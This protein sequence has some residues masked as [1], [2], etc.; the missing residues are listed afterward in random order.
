MEGPRPVTAARFH[1]NGIVSLLIALLL[2]LATGCSDSSPTTASGGSDLPLPAPEPRLATRSGPGLGNLTY[3]PAELFTAI[4]RVDESNDIPAQA[5]LKPF[6]TNVATMV[7][8]WFFTLFA[9][10]SG[11]GPGGLL[12]YDV[13]DPRHPEARQAPVRAARTHR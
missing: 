8:G 13:S 4:A 2:A 5:S 3:E 7:D 9:P 6:G 1:R 10:D 12:F 11:F